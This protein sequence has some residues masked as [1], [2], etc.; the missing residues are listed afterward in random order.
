VKAGCFTWRSKT[1][2]CWRKKAFSAMSSLW[3]L[4]KSA[5]VASIKLYTAGFVM[6]LTRASS[7]S[8]A[9]RNIFH[10]K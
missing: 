4:I 10:S 3:L 9:Q 7:L 2:S 5:A 6:A 1:I 8:T